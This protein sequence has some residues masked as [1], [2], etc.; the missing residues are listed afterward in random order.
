MQEISILSRKPV[1]FRKANSSKIL[2]RLPSTPHKSKKNFSSKI[3]ELENE[4]SLLTSYSSDTIYRLDYRNMKYDYISPA[5]KMLLG[6]TAQE[7]KNINFRSLIVETKIVTDG[8]RKIDSFDELEKK[9]IAGDIGKWQADY[10]IRTKTGDKIWVSDVSWPWFDANGKVIGS[11][12]SLRDI[13]DRVKMELQLEQRIKD[14][15]IKDTLTELDNKQKFDE[16]LEKEFKR[17]TR[18]KSELSIILFD[19]DNLKKINFE[20]GRDAGDL[21][22]KNFAKLLKSSLR[23]TDFLARLENALFGL[24]LPDTDIK[25]AYFVAERLRIDANRQEFIF[26]EGKQPMHYSFSAGIASATIDESSNPQD[27]YKVADTRLYIAK[28]TGR[29]QVSIDE[30]ISFVNL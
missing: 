18:N 15:T 29:N 14:L 5:I 11:V 25:G 1:S 27:L 4:I 16:N 10:L 23:E 24:V 8:F 2:D 6:F 28:N 12:G 13:E 22:I 7:M 21:L 9:R 17:A 26:K 20:H 30:L 3:A 19:L